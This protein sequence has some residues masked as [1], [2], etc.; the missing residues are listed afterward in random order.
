MMGQNFKM[1]H[2]TMTK[3][4]WGLTRDM[5]YNA[6]ICAKFEDYFFT[7]FSDMNVKIKGGLGRL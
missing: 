3:P 1:D 2:V 5:A 4:I 6:Y 7:C